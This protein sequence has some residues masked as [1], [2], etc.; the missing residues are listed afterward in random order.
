MIAFQFKIICY[1]WSRNN[2]PL[3]KEQFFVCYMKYILLWKLYGMVLLIAYLKQSTILS[4][5]INYFMK[6]F[7]HHSDKNFVENM[8]K[9]GSER[10]EKR[11]KNTLE[12]M[13]VKNG[14]FLCFVATRLKPTNIL[15]ADI[16]AIILIISHGWSIYW[17]IVSIF[18]LLSASV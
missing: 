7:H 4:T 14:I 18:E 9:W 8:R 2:W 11:N 13:E 16:I 5:P 6:I 15:I 17:T 12:W 10:K 3:Q 1:T